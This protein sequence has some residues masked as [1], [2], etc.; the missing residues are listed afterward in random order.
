P[1]ESAWRG[2]L[3]RLLP[4]L[5]TPAAGGT[6]TRQLFEA[7]AHLVGWLAARHPLVLILEDLQWAD[8]M[9]VRLLA[10]LGRRL[11]GS[12]VLLI[13]TAREEELADAPLLRRML[14]DLRREDSLV[15]LLLGPLSRAET[16]ALV[17]TLARAGTDE[18]AVARL[19][20]QVWRAT[21]GNPFIVVETMRSLSEGTIS[22]VSGTP[23]VPQRVREVVARRLERLGE[24]ARQLAAVAAVIGREFDFALVQRAAGLEEEGAAQGMEELVRRRVLSGVGERFDFSHDRIREVAYRQLL[25]PRR[26][27]LH[28]RVA[29]ALEALHANDL[30]PHAL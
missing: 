21:E 8:E 16:L 29:E 18:D 6:G 3:A 27:L 13:T 20:E 14:E 28:R 9:S 4:E 7:V 10:F 25:P 5:G 30:R 12:S 22:A 19:G 23:P 11:G 24:P 15:T 17:G 1:A 26:R 2:E